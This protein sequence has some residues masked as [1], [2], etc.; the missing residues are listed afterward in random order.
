[1]T[2]AF[3]INAGQPVRGSTLRNA[4]SVVRGSNVRI[5][6][7]GTGFVVS[8]EGLALDNAAP[9]AMVQVMLQIALRQATACPKVRSGPAVTET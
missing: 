1:M 6:A 3:R 4:Q 7:R 8:S 9:G 2:A 5:N